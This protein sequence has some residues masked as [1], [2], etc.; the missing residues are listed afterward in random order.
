MFPKLRNYLFTLGFCGVFSFLFLSCSSISVKNSENPEIVYNEAV[1]L[2]D[3]ERFI[4]ATELLNEIRL[5]FPQ[6]RFFALADLKTGD[7]YF[8]QESYTEA[9][10]AY[11]TFIDLYPNHPQADYAF[12]QKIKSFYFDTPDIAARDQ[13]PALDAARS[14][15]QFLRR[16]PKSQYVNEA[17]TIRLKS[18]LK[19]AEKEAYIA[20]FYENRQKFESSLRRW[21]NILENF[22]ELKDE[23][24]AKDLY[25]EAKSKVE[26]FSQKTDSGV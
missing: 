9:A 26:K 7:L 19:L 21:K 17:Q 2:I 16:Y 22:S 5:R 15:E 10:A 11:S 20:R 1:K 12:F 6:S 24:L 8:K 3:N 14:A 13:G 18:L 23:P 25:S 4:E